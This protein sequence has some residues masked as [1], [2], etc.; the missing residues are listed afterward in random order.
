[1]DLFFS[2]IQ[3]IERNDEI[4]QGNLDSKKYGNMFFNLYFLFQF[5]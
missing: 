2:A 3:I 5:F 4:W 1:M